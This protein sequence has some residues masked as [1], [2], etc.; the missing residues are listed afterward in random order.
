MNITADTKK[1]KVIQSSDGE[2]HLSLEID[3]SD[4]EMSDLMSPGAR[5]RNKMKGEIIEEIFD[6]ALPVYEESE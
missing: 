6:S 1:V 3:L 2:W 5:A 4:D